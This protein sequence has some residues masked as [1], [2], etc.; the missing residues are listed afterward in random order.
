MFAE[1][2]AFVKVTREEDPSDETVEDAGKEKW[3]QIEDHNI[4]EIVALE[5]KKKKIQMIF[6]VHIINVS[7]TYI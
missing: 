6:D 1:L 2:W 3:N 7:S 5:F 4:R